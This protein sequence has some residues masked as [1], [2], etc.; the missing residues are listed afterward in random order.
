MGDIEYNEEAQHPPLFSWAQL[1]WRGKVNWNDK[2]E[3]WDN[4]E[5]DGGSIGMLIRPVSISEQGAVSSIRRG[6]CGELMA[7]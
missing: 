5:G 4:P 3:T 7:S 6:H 1:T 2:V